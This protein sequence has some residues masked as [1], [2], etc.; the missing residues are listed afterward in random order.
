MSY[1]RKGITE[2]EI[3]RAIKKHVDMTCP[4]AKETVE[5]VLKQLSV[6]M[7]PDPIELKP[8][9]LVR[10][11]GGGAEKKEY[12]GVVS[13]TRRIEGQWGA[14]YH[15]WWVLLDGELKPTDNFQY[16]SDRTEVWHEG[17]WRKCKIS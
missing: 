10:Y 2:E 12:R 6:D 1:E 5:K 8:G 7:Y 9:M 16:R 11:F 4:E 3:R 15:A 17:K 13:S 14:D